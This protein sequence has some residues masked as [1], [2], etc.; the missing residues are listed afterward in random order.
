MNEQEPVILGIGLCYATVCSPLPAT[1]TEEWFCRRE[2]SGTSRGWSLSDDK[3]F[4]NGTPNPCVCEK[5]PTRKH[6]L[7][8]C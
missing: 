7:F 4:S 6:Y 8:D 1:E 2:I 5:D 3:E